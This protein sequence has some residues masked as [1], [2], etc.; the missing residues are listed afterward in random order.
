M[1]TAV[2]SANSLLLAIV[3]GGCA[4][5][6]PDYGG[7]PAPMPPPTPKAGPAP[8]SE[9]DSAPAAP[10]PGLAQLPDPIVYPVQKSKRGNRPY[11]V[12]GKRY[13]V[14]ETASGY[15]QVGRASWYGVKFNGRQTSSGEVFDMFQLTAA[16][17]SLPI[18]TYVRVT[19]LDNDR[20]SIVRVNDRGPFH[21]ERIIDLSYAAAV[22]LGFEDHGTARVRVEAVSAPPQPPADA[23]APFF[24]R[25]GSFSEF[26]VAAAACDELAPLLA[27]GAHVVRADDAYSVRVGPL[28][29]R[30]ALERLKAIL[31][32][33]ERAPV[34]VEE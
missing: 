29:T 31:T 5:T 3:L 10:P 2:R 24:V 11:T 20:Q 30:S 19:N 13:H 27:V 34:I 6:L 32:F 7:A 18:P 16:H 28:A 26:T 4:G 22:K 12:W 23:A 15:D 25:A 9:V 21:A 14:L 33:Q 1:P 8:A 17:R